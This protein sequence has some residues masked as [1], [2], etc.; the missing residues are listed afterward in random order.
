MNRKSQATIL[1]LQFQ[2]GLVGKINE[3]TLN[4]L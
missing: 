1:K 3:V 2:V 4:L